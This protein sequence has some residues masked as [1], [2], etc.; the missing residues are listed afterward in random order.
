MHYP[1]TDVQVVQRWHPITRAS[2]WMLATPENRDLW[3]L[4]G[5]WRS[6]AEAASHLTQLIEEGNDETA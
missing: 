6:E 3:H 1:L 4:G 5:P 2:L